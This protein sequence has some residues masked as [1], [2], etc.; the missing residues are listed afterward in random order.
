MSPGGAEDIE[1]PTSPFSVLKKADF[2]VIEALN[3]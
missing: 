1:H 3:G 2:K